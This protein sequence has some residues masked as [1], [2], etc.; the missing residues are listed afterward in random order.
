MKKTYIT[1]ALEVIRINTTMLLAMSVSETE[2]DPNDALGRDDNNSGN[3]NHPSP[4]N[5]WDQAW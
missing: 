1:P 2:V 5:L 3:G 4:P